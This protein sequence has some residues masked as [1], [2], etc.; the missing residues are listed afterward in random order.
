MDVP[1][2]E[3]LLELEELEL[4]LEEL[5][6]LD[7]LEEL[8]ELELDELDELELEELLLDAS[9]KASVVTAPVASVSLRM[10]ALPVSATYKFVPAA[11][12]A[13]SCGWLNQA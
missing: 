8:E 7:E 11:S 6:E 13:T 10:A 4:E 12:R 2:E 1:P 5:L 3:L 9:V